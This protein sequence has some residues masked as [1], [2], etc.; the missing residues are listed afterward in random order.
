ML[1][2]AA[3]CL[4]PAFLV[5]WFVTGRM[6]VWAPRWGLI[7]RPAARKVHTT[8]TPLGGGVGIVAGFAATTLAAY[9]AVAWAAAQSSPP[10]WL[11]AELQPHLA[12]VLSRGG[13]LGVLLAAGVLLAVMGLLDDFRGLSWRARL[14]VHFA[15][16]G[17]LVASGVRATVF[18]SHPWFGAGLT[19]LWIV[20]LINS[21]NFLDNMDALS[22][23]IGMIAALNFSAIMLLLTPEPRW[24]VGGALLALAGSLG[25]FLVHNRPPARIFMGDAGATF[26]GLMLA[27]L[28]VVG[29]FYDAGRSG[30]HVILAPLCVLAIPLYDAASV[31]LIRLREGRSPFEPDKKHF[32]HRLVELGLSKK[33]AVMVVHLV[34]ATTGLGGLLLYRVPDWSSALLVVALVLCL[35][36]IVAILETVGRGGVARAS[37][38]AA[39]L[40]DGPFAPPNSGAT[41]PST[42][43]ATEGSPSAGAQSNEP[44]AAGP[45]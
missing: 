8:P 19:V 36:A 32:S 24:F 29:T 13:Q 43:S 37:Q 44:P 17:A 1:S 18:V 25:G 33:H 39:S 12:G 41:P 14:A 22:S 40:S 34:T 3:A 6:Q 10:A 27:A 2:F 20:T 23:G 15:L 11:P 16:A 7:D 31:V 42:K 4:A 9:A 21:F 30:R 5:A 45:A 28:T 38:S 35:L 26:I